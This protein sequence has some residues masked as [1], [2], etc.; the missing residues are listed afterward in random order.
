MTNLSKAFNE[1]R[2]LGYFA[3]QNYWCCQTCAT[4][5][6]EEFGYSNKYVYYHSQDNWD[7][8]NTEYF[9]LGWNGD[10]ELICNTLEK[11]GV[12]ILDKDPEY[13][14]KV[15]SRSVKTKQGLLL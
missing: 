2:K 5:E 12:V 15:L 6:I 3:K 4:Y 13:R 10:F 1:L 14:I 7:K 11:Y 8:K 9:C